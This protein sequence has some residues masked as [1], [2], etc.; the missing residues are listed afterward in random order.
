MNRFDPRFCVVISLAVCMALAFMTFPAAPVVPR[1]V[2]KSVDPVS[3]DW[4]VGGGYRDR[5]FTYSG[6]YTAMLEEVSLFHGDP[7]MIVVRKLAVNAS[8]TSSDVCPYPWTDY[9]WQPYGNGSIRCDIITYGRL[10]HLKAW[11]E[12]GEPFAIYIDGQL[13]AEAPSG[14]FDG[15]LHPFTGH[16]DYWGIVNRTTGEVKHFDYDIWCECA[17]A[18]EFCTLTGQPVKVF[19]TVEGL[20]TYAWVANYRDQGSYCEGT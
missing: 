18:L 4:D 5:P 19:F 15:D 8:L 2:A 10:T 7:N 11:S 16:I 12:H 6:E 13:Y 14:S 3:G 1:Q 20:A 17:G 9:L